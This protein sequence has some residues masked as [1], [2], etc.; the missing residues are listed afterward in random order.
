MK[1]CDELLLCTMFLY[2]TQSFVI[3]YS[4]L[5]IKKNSHYDNCYIVM[6]LYQIT[7]GLLNIKEC[8]IY[9]KLGYQ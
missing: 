8:S 4:W 3:E 6:Y 5:T 1:A 7:K 2:K 9:V